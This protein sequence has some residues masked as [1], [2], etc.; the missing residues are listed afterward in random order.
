VSAGDI[1]LDESMHMHV[2]AFTPL[3]AIRMIAALTDAFYLSCVCRSCRSHLLLQS[4]PLCFL[5][6]SSEPSV[7]EKF[8]L[9]AVQTIGS[10][11][12]AHGR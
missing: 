10:V 3:W 12:D 8:I 11:R 2:R 6:A 7:M 1:N 9:V 4:L 5:S